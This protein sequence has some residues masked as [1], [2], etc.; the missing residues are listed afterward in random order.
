[1]I[2]LDDVLGSRVNIAILRYLSA[3]Q[4]GLSGNDIAKRLE[5]Q[6]SSARQALE[7]LVD[8]GVITR[9]DVGR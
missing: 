6:Q 9:T 3:I 8:T 2:V 7:R 5:I 1:M 4:G